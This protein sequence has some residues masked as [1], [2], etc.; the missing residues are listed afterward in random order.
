MGGFLFFCFVILGDLLV[1]NISHKRSLKGKSQ[2]ILVRM[3]RVALG[4]CSDVL[5]NI[6]RT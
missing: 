3:K 5:F 4:I 6:K 1:L 2:A